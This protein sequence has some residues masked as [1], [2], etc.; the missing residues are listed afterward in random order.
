[1]KRLPLLLVALL[2]LAAPA[3]AD[4]VWEKQLGEEITAV[5][6]DERG[7]LIFVGTEGGMV[8]CYNSAGSVVW[9]EQVTTPSGNRPI[10][11]LEVG[12]DR[13]K[14]S[15]LGVPGRLEV[16]DVSTGSVYWRNQ[17][18]GW[19]AL[20]RVAISQ[21]G[22]V[23]GE[24][25]TGQAVDLRNSDG[26][27][28]FRA[29]GT[30]T[31]VCLSG[32]G[33]W[34]CTA[35][36][37]TLNL[38]D[39]NTPDWDGWI[40][41]YNGFAWENRAAHTITGSTDGALTNYPIE[42]TVIRGSG[43]ST[44][45]TLYA[46]ECRADFADIRF[47]A[48]DGKTQLPYYLES[49]N[50]NTAK[51]YVKIPSIPKS[52]G[53]TTIYVYW[54]NP[55]ATTTTSDPDARWIFYDDFEDGVINPSLWATSI[56]GSGATVQET[57]GYLDLY[58]SH[59][60]STYA[61]L[62]GPTLRHGP[63]RIITNI[64][65][66]EAPNQERNT[67]PSLDGAWTGVF[68]DAFAGGQKFHWGSYT[69][70][71]VTLDSP[72]QLDARYTPGGS[73]T[74]SYG[75]DFNISREG[76]AS[77][78]PLVFRAG[79]YDEFVSGHMRIYDIGVTS[80]NTVE[81][82]PRSWGTVHSVLTPLDTKTLDGTIIDIDAPETGDWVAVST[83]TKTYI[84]QITDTGFGTT[85]STDRTGTPYQ[86][87]VADGGSFAIEGRNILA[88]I[89]R[90][91]AV[92]VGTYTTGGAAQ[93]VAIAQ[94]NGLYAAAGSDDGKYYVFSKDAASSWYLLHASDSYDP[95]TALAMTWRGE[96]LIIGR[97]DGR[98]TAFQV[99]E[100][101]ATGTIK[102]NV[103]KDNKPYAA[104][105][106]HI[107]DGGTNQ[108]WSA[109]ITVT[110][111]DYG[112]A[113]VPVQWGHY[114]RITAGDDELSRVLVATP[115]QAEYVLRI[116]SPAPLRTGAQ[117]A[118][119]YD[120]NT[121][122]IYLSYDDTRQKTHRVVYQIVRSS[123]NTVVFEREYTDA[124][125]PLTDYYQI[126]ADW[127]N[128]SYRV[129]LTASGSP[130]FTNTWSQWVGVDG[131]AKLPA[132][133]DNYMKMGICF[134]LLLFVAGL[135]SYLTGPQGAVVVSMLAGALVLWG[136]LPLP[137]TIIALCIVWAFLGLLGR[138]SGESDSMARGL[139]IAVWIFAVNAVFTILNEINPFASE[140]DYTLGNELIDLAAG[141]GAVSEVSF[142][143][144]A[145]IVHALNIFLDLILGPFRL[146][147]QL[148]A[149]IGV[150]GVLNYTLTGCIW[151][152]YGY[153][154]FQL[155]TGRSLGDMR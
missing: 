77:V 63:H 21:T 51:F 66:H 34:G 135:F 29:T 112:V 148:M 99:S 57:N 87:Q 1:M 4:E 83:T 62:S 132:V 88:D 94:K 146:A 16:R 126:P 48:S 91:D 35:S 2:L 149:M 10:G 65:F 36:G 124:D 106:L 129:H 69:E 98:L 131:G 32:E 74:Y 96:L 41:S 9:S 140:L 95:V 49:V 20:G 110:T 123:D 59:L 28:I 55:A 85:Y 143:G 107:E 18:G 154:I 152:V 38:Y 139:T 37:T 133:L 8:Y 150:T 44:G 78:V 142:L 3:A 79:H 11:A 141:T 118:S 27:R 155:I 113:V 71:S 122:R 76:G 97:A 54:A 68:S 52:P 58:A 13:L 56:V 121:Q 25:W 144:A 111:D 70:F 90:I 46:P 72:H 26:N 134:F 22:D 151:L 81:F 117:Y 130:S 136:W 89:F 92:Q 73:A 120:P 82:F 42:I 114:L 102:L 75:G 84:I 50:G 109:P 39:I 100:Q 125:L 103:F 119:S 30:Y 53:T 105:T 14:I 116:T 80:Y 40:A 15:T 19:G 17:A 61:T 115:A 128:T 24:I 101:D 93:H 153:F 45:S 137:P 67:L 104:A 47:T 5:A 60:A 23:S 33:D 86:I 127:T 145:E 7:D 138:T 12:G 147:P 108:E 43:T 6:T 64:S 31:D